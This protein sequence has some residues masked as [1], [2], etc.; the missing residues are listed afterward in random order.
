MITIVKDRE[1]IYD[2]DD[3]DVVLLGL[4]T[5]NILMGNFLTMMGIKYPI[6]E[7]VNDKSPYAD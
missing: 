5:H 7:E 3:Y 2:T 1:P 4:S 6:V